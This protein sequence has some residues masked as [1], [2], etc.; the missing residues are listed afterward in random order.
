MANT[1]Y[2]QRYLPYQLETLKRQMECVEYT[3]NSYARV[4]QLL[5]V[6]TQSLHIEFTLLSM[7]RS[8]SDDSAENPRLDFNPDYWIRQFSRFDMDTCWHPY[9]WEIDC[10]SV[11]AVDYDIHSTLMVHQVRKEL[12]DG[13]AFYDLKEDGFRSD[14]ANALDFALKHVGDMDCHYA[15]EVAQDAI[16]QLVVTIDE[17]A[18]VARTKC[19]EQIPSMMDQQK[20]VGRKATSCF[21][22]HVSVDALKKDVRR[23][24]ETIPSTDGEVV[25]GGKAYDRKYVF[26]LLYYRFIRMGLAHQ[27]P[28]VLSYSMFLTEALDLEGNSSSFRKCLNNWFQKITL[29]DCTFDELTPEKIR[30]RCFDQQMTEE[31]FSVWTF[32]DGELSKVIDGMRLGV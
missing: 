28:N 29:Y 32:V 16:D 4:S 30:N 1:Y 9:D 17:V 3:L 23:L 6:T 5:A 31:E 2:E 22:P 13:R 24:F 11:Y 15:Q 7:L 10:E 12:E 25:L 21:L 18:R 14:N 8:W 27:R 20:R 26:V 19:Y